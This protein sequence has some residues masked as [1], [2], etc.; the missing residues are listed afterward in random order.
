MWL[1]TVCLNAALWDGIGINNRCSNNKIAPLYMMYKV[2]ID[3][4]YHVITAQNHHH[5]L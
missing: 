4:Q 5:S 2:H 1:C 3:I